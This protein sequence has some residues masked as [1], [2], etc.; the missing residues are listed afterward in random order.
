M[1]GMTQRRLM[2]IVPSGDA[3]LDLTPDELAWA[4]L[5]DMQARE[6]DRIAG[7]ANRD[8]LANSLSPFGFRP[9][10]QQHEVMNRLNKAGRQAFAQLERWDLIE[11]ADDMNGRNGYVVL[12]PKGRATTERTDFE[13]VRGVHAQP[14]GIFDCNRGAGQRVTPA[15]MVSGSIG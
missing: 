9:N 1:T 8:G 6:H 10:P 4:L 11:P 7:M 13:R 5:E 3:L 14:L 12:T 2:Q 15:R